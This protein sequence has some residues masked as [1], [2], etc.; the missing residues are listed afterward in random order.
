MDR[1]SAIGPSVKSLIIT[2]GTTTQ[3]GGTDSPIIC[4]SPNSPSTPASISRYK[5]ATATVINPSEIL[6]QLPQ[7]RQHA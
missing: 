4:A 5:E 2:L 7:T 6:F 1:I 3:P